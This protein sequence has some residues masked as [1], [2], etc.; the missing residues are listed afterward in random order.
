MQAI[1]RDIERERRITQNDVMRMYR[2]LVGISTDSL[3][4]QFIWLRSKE[5]RSVFEEM[6]FRIIHRILQDRKDRESKKGKK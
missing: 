4:I 1:R 5:K 2:E 6:K 3:A